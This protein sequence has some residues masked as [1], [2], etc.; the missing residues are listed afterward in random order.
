MPRIGLVVLSFWLM[1]CAT[2]GDDPSAQSQ[3]EPSDIQVAEAVAE[4]NENVADDKDRVICTRERV[5]GTHF[6]RRICRTVR[7]IE[8][9][10]GVARRSIED[11]P[12]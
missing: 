4:H 5:V 7:Q 11:Q 2:S 12:L 3:A 6:S 10:R 9:D 1:G 8:D